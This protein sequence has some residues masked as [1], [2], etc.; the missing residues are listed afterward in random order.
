[1]ARNIGYLQ[2]IQLSGTERC[3]QFPDMGHQ[4]LPIS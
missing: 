1:M 2:A 4:K 3:D